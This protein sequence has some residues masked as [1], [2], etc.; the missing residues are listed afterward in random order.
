MSTVHL[1]AAISGLQH[2]LPHG[3]LSKPL[4]GALF[5]GPGNLGTE[6]KAI[7]K[8]VRKVT[9]TPGCQEVQK[10]VHQPCLFALKL[11]HLL[12][13]FSS[14]SLSVTLEP[15]FQTFPNTLE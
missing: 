13:P 7:V 6:N 4:R 5:C 8:P 15:T 2:V 12:P 1:N 11:A 3:A 9:N 10:Q 14:F